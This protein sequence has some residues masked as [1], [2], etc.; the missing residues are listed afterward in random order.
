MMM[1]KMNLGGIQGMRFLLK[2]VSV[3]CTVF[4]RTLCFHRKLCVLLNFHAVSN[5]TVVVTR[6]Y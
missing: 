3:H 1:M 6:Q 2:V 5:L 4:S